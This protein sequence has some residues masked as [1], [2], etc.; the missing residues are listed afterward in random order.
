ME[1]V[2][3]P[4]STS[5][6]APQN[7]E[8]R[9]LGFLQPPTLP[10]VVS[11]PSSASHLVAAIAFGRNPLC[12]TMHFVVS[13]ASNPLHISS[14]TKAGVLEVVSERSR[15]SNPAPTI[16]GGSVSHTLG[17]GLL[18][19][20]NHSPNTGGHA[21]GGVRAIERV[22][23]RRGLE[24]GT[25]SHHQPST[26]NP[27]PSTINPWNQVLPYRC[28]LTKSETLDL[29]NPQPEIRNPK[30]STINPNP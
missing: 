6:L 17:L 23:P 4:T 30:P 15:A 22:Q 28:F 7:Q 3:E 26:L 29:L 2:S 25:P 21:G 18:K 8:L 19:T 27:Q 9:W 10:Q 13:E 14:H 5:N 20:L 24:P 16:L 11:K 1:A 12:N